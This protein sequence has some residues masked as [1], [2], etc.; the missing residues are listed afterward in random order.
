M[1]TRPGSASRWVCTNATTARWGSPYGRTSPAHGRTTT[2]SSPGWSCGPT[3]RSSPL[4]GYGWIFGMGDGT[5]NVGLGILN[6]S[7]A[8]GKVDYADL[9]KQW[10]KVTP[11]E[12]QFRDEF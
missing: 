5:V 9:L 8:F 7:E 10:L 11:D 4:P 6:T 12:W 3:T 1:A 2:T